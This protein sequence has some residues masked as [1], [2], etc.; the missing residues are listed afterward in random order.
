MLFLVWGAYSELSLLSAIDLNESQKEIFMNNSKVYEC[1]RLKGEVILLEDNIA[2]QMAESVINKHS[3]CSNAHTPVTHTHTHT[4][5]AN[6]RWFM[7]VHFLL[8]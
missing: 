2:K 1:Q 6:S 8:F 3:L 4:Q 5:S 7:L